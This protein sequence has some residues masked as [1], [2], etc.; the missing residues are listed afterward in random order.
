MDSASI[1]TIDV[2]TVTTNTPDLSLATVAPDTPVMG[3]TVTPHPPDQV[4]TTNPNMF[5]RTTCSKILLP[6]G[7]YNYQRNNGLHSI[8]SVKSDKGNFDEI[9]GHYQMIGKPQ[10]SKSGRGQQ[11]VYDQ[12][13]GGHKRTSLQIFSAEVRE[14]LL[15]DPKVKK[16]DMDNIIIE[17]WINLTPEMKKKYQ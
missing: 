16:E 15:K 9:E 5:I 7:I 14:Q 17:R 1:P 11:S 6:P 4:I 2:S 8:M 3:G 12:A 10:G 13:S